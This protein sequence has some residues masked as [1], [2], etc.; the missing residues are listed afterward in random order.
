MITYE[1][2]TIGWFGCGISPTLFHNHLE[3]ALAEGAIYSRA[4]VA[5]HLL[6][7]C[8]SLC[9]SPEYLQHAFII[10]ISKL[11]CPSPRALAY[12]D[13]TYIPCGRITG[14][15][16]GFENRANYCHL[17]QCLGT[18]SINHHNLTPLA[19]YHWCEEYWHLHRLCI[20]SIYQIVKYLCIY[21]YICTY[22]FTIHTVK[23]YSAVPSIFSQI[24]TVDTP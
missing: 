2:R 1:S 5:V 9:W 14:N 24:P 4:V 11:C 3:H 21:I 10:L 7:L 13:I 17:R 6:K 16:N 19:F 15:W 23:L 12:I 8:S 22:S 18:C 20:L